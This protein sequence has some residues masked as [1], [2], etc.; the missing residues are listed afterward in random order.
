MSTSLVYHAFG[1][2]TYDYR[3]TEYKD[4]AV[5]SR[6]GSDQAKVLICLD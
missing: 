6:L 2:R 5:Y 1:V 3:R 4:G